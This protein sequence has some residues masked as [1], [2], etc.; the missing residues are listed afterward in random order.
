[1]INCKKACRPD[2]ARAGPPAPV[3]RRA[4]L[5]DGA[6]SRP[7]ASRRG[8]LTREVVVC[9]GGSCRAKRGAELLLL[10]HGALKVG[11]LY[12]LFRG[13]RFT[14]LILGTSTRQAQMKFSVDLLDWSGDQNPIGSCVCRVASLMQ[15]VFL[16]PDV[17]RSVGQTQAKSMV[18][19]SVAERWQLL[20]ML[21]GHVH[22]PRFRTPLSP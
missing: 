2:D 11:P 16:G 14:A 15:P 5:A 22:T 21:L 17:G 3:R 10:R 13:R 7:P 4:L 9:L 18:V 19:N 12:N 8:P 20:H 1:M 6:T